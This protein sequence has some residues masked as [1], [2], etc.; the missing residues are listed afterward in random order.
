MCPVSLL[1]S[2]S[3]LTTSCSSLRHSAL[4]RPFLSF[5]PHVPCL[6]DLMFSSAN[7][8]I[9]P[10]NFT[11]RP[12]RPLQYFARSFDLSILLILYIRSRVYVHWQCGC[13]I[14]PASHSS[15]ISSSCVIRA[16]IH[17]VRSNRRNQTQTKSNFFLCILPQSSRIKID[18]Q[19]LSATLA[20]AP[21]RLQIDPC[22]SFTE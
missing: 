18:P 2:L 6:A 11:F 14:P 3:Y 19:L 5:L 1:C 16:I 12:L 13:R 22:L 7:P 15:A 9:S 8:P 17:R 10:R 21:F 20:N 4:T